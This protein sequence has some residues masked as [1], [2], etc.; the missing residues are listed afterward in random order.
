M[1]HSLFS[2]KGLFALVTVFL[3]SLAFT[4]WGYLWYATVFD[5]VWQG[6]IGRTEVELIGISE[7]RGHIQ[8]FLSYFISFV[9]A[10][11]LYFLCKI[12]RAK[13][14]WDFQIVA[15]IISVLIATPVLGNA[16]LFAGQSLHLW[17]LDIAHFILGYAGMALIFWIA[18][19]MTNSKTS[20]AS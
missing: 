16:V 8:T 20:E 15:A 14:F 19:K 12:S 4:L 9:Q 17:G 13:S 6:L 10:G 5:D 2:S 11:A 18:A 1:L 7:Q 3:A